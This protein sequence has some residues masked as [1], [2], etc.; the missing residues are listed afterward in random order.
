MWRASIKK[1]NN[2]IKIRLNYDFFTG[3]HGVLHQDK[4]KGERMT[5]DVMGGKA[6][7]N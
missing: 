1:R 6:M 4:Y 7:N 2:S 5:G 3:A